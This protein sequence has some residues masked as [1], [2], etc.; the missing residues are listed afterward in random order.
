[1][2]AFKVGKILG[3]LFFKMFFDRNHEKTPVPIPSQRLGLRTDLWT[4]TH[5]P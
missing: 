1:M 5:S 3:E 2:A 4:G